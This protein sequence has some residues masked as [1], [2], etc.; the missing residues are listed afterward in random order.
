ME[1][2]YSFDE[3]SNN[4]VELKSKC[5]EA[6]HVLENVLG[7]EKWSRAHFPGNRYDAMT[8]NI[9]E[10]TAL[11][12]WKSTL[13]KQNNSLLA[14]RQPSSDACSDWYGVS[15]ING[16]VNRLNITNASVFGTHYDFPFSSL[17]FLEYFELSVNNLSGTI[18]PEI[19]NLTNLIYLDLSMNQISGTIPPEIGKMMS[20]L[21]LSIHTNNL[22]GLIPKTIGEL[23][24]LKVLHLYANQLSGSIPSE[25]GNLKKKLKDLNLFNN[26]LSGPIPS[27]LGNLKKPPLSETIQ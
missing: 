13:K 6:A 8:T 7:F 26:Q 2:A 21:N 23:T 24:E 4:F 18:P 25:L 5:P 17:P 3:F 20:L 15:C 1:K 14:S 11:L 9:V 27:E 16:R 10:A 22:Y 12:K 19:G